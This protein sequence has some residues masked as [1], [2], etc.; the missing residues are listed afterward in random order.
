MSPDTALPIADA[1]LLAVEG[2]TVAFGR[3]PQ[4]VTALQSICFDLRRGETLALVGESG[5]G[6]S[7]C[8]LSIMGLLPPGAQAT[9]GRVVLETEDLLQASAAA[10]TALRGNRIAMV[11]QEPM[12]S[13]N[14]VLTIGRQLTEGM[15]IHLSVTRAEAEA[16]ALE[17]LTQVGMT[18]PRRRLRQYP[19]QLSGGMRQRVMIA[20][21]LACHPD[22]II[23][24]EP[25]TAL[26]VSIQAQIIDLLRDIKAAAG[27]A[28]LLITHDL[29]VV[30]EMADRIAVLY[31]GHVVEI[32]PAATLFDTPRH[33]YTE[34]LLA[35]VPRLDQLLMDAP[36]RPRLAE[37]P[38]SV[39]AI[40]ERPSGCP[41]R[42]RCALAVTR[43]AEAMPPMI[44]V[45][46]THSAA[47][48]VRAA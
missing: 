13:L 10:L 15:E 43:C 18:E 38:G 42:P 41:F 27:T 9:A 4:E 2:L 33:P 19:H 47:C 6:K 5:S 12:T 8:A 24:D 39:P 22:L 14:P 28:I 29:G 31:A 35:A 44:A 7:L 30:A 34:S 26:D 20:M 40:S 3:A 37:L 21:A 45:S 25:T 16:R 23:A 36:V 46:A 17:L 48:W 11:F 32:A 1:T